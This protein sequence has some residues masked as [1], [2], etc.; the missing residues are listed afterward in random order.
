MSFN[1]VWERVKQIT[2]WKKYG[3]LASFVGST[4]QSISGVKGRGIFPLEWAFKIAQY[5]HSY[6]DW[7]L[8][9]EGPTRRGETATHQTKEFSAW[10]DAANDVNNAS[11]GAHRE[12]VTSE[13]HESH[14]DPVAKA[15]LGDWLLLSDVAKMRIWTLVK[16]EL[17]KSRS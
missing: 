13:T 9:G 10:P 7:L 4:P 5:Y 1:E 8:T 14:E 17:E 3:E 2:G 16:E 6:T 12:Y 15:F 11:K